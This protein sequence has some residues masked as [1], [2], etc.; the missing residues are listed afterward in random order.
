MI[1]WITL[2]VISLLVSFSAK[3][4]PIVKVI[5]FTADWCS[6]CLFL[7]PILEDAISSFEAEDI[8][9]VDIDMTRSGFQFEEP[10]QVETWN[11]AYR[12]AN[13]H[14]AAYLVDWYGNRTGIAV[15]IAADTGEPITCLQ[16]PLD[17]NQIM[18]RLR[19]A[20]IFTQRRA[21]G[22]RMP[23]GPECEPPTR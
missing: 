4:D 18:G 13:T 10:E 20:Q 21:P 15:V 12:L 2:A 17:L 11:A 14:D 23:N 5:Y 3:A 16:R 19:E 1:R 22:A 9:R 6:N 7:D 8:E